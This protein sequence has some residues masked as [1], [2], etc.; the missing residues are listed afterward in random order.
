VYGIGTGL[1]VVVF[2]ILLGAGVQWVGTAFNRI[3]V[4]ERWA[5]RV[6]AV[7]VIGVGV[8]Y[9]TTFTVARGSLL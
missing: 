8:Y 1:P 3:S 4:F 9:T 5:R 2:A 7:A 6:T